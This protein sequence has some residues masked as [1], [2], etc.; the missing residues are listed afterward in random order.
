MF[1]LRVRI[2]VFWGKPFII[3]ARYAQIRERPTASSYIAVM[4]IH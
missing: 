2:R 1:P 4:I 3:H